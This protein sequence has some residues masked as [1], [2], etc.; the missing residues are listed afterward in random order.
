[1]PTFLTCVLLASI[2]CALLSFVFFFYFFSNTASKSAKDFF[3]IGGTT[4][5]ELFKIIRYRSARFVHA[6]LKYRLAYV[7]FPS[8]HRVRYTADK[9][10]VE[11]TVVRF[12]NRTQFP[13]E[14]STVDLP[15]GRYTLR[16]VNLYPVK[17]F[18]LAPKMPIISA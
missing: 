3:L 7:Y 15:S 5:T 14:N 13:L 17:V 11:L 18:L 10:G 12:S 8:V 16:V 6:V 4:K 9:L 2:S 1:M